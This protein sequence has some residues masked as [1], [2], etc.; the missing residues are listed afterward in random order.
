MNYQF[1]RI[2]V[3]V[4]GR[5]VK[6]SFNNPPM[7]L[8]D[9]V[10]LKEL[11]QLTETVVADPAV[12]VLV[13][14]S[15]D[16]EFFI[17][18]AEIARLYEFEQVQIETPAES[19]EV[20]QLQNI[21]ERLRTM[22]KITIVQIAGRAGGCGAEIS[23]ACDMRFGAI[24]EAVFN[25]PAVPLGSTTGGGGSQ[26][27]PRV[28][29]KARAME[30]LLGGLD[31]DAVTAERWG[32]LNRALPPHELEDFVD[33]TARRIASCPPEAVRITK[34]AIALS[35]LPLAEGLHEEDVLFRQLLESET[36]LANVR[37]FIELG[38]QTREREL[39]MQELTKDLL[40]TPSPTTTQHG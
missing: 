18:H 28:I 12:L 30:L 25:N 33:A 3:V 37:R 26:Y 15:T 6:A 29:G 35:D 39:N 11:D 24:G 32:Y 4:E 27:M 9:A 8:L 22:D 16:P 1:E 34:K 14:K 36:H 7:N 5:I 31:L 20:N 21:C 2:D 19:V 13:L 10:M 38:G 40:G 23:L 17:A